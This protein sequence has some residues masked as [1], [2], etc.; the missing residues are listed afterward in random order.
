MKIDE[1]NARFVVPGYQAEVMETAGSGEADDQHEF[2][3]YSRVS[4]PSAPAPGNWKELLGLTKIAPDPTQLDPPVKPQSFT[5]Y[6]RA[7]SGTYYH[8]LLQISP[9]KSVEASGAAKVQQ[10]ID[11]LDLYQ[12][13]ANEIRARALRGRTQ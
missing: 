6:G 11:L 1:L 8:R 10:M 4:Y 7:A 5:G 12:Q 9:G 13:S 2:A 3:P